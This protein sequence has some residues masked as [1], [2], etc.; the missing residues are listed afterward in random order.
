MGGARL[1]DTTET[2]AYFVRRQTRSWLPARASSAPSGA[3]GSIR[4]DRGSNIA[5]DAWE[6]GAPCGG[7]AG[8]GAATG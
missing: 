8:I 3:V 7:D 4:C 6:N 2:L 5:A 1:W